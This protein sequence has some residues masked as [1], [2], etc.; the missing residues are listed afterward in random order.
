[1][2][3]ILSYEQSPPMSV[4]LPFYLAGTAWGVAA[5]AL[6]IWD[7]D[8]AVT[9][10][11]WSPAVMGGTHLVTLGV[12]AHFMIG[13]LF[14]LLP[15]VAG[16]GVAGGRVSAGLVLVGLSAGTFLLAA[17]LAGW[18]PRVM[19]AAAT[20]L[21]P[22]TVGFAA[23]LAHAAW[24]SPSWDGTGVTFRLAGLTLAA[25][26]VL[27]VLL[28][29]GAGAGLPVNV[30]LLLHL[31]V[32]TGALGWVLLLMVGVA[33]T[34]VPLFQVT[35]P[36]PPWL[37]RMWPAAMVSAL[38]SLAVVLALAPQGAPA[39]DAVLA[40]LVLVGCGQV[41]R[42]QAQSKRRS[43]VTRRFWQGAM[44]AFVL[45][46][47][48]WLAQLAWPAQFSP[49]TVHWWLGVL[50]LVAGGMGATHGMVFKIV[51]FLV[52]LHLKNQLPRRTPIP[53]MGQVIA[54]RPQRALLVAFAGVCVLLLAA[55]MS[56]GLAQAAGVALALEQL[57]LGGLLLRAVGTYQ[58]VLRHPPPLVERHRPPPADAA[59][60]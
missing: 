60:A 33:V 23:L 52:W 16:V 30:P 40:L 5:G 11:R 27:G 14:Q 44:G 56:R 24:R 58:R 59:K 25:V 12:L 10:G 57:A 20:V 55:P 7:V 36:F 34:V 42:L 17:G 8:S 2:S 43:D 51:P 3:T 1:M 22:T 53:T 47:L 13:S 28:V 39:L 4:P 29:A 45:A 31:H 37:G 18:M 49:R 48:L 9:L 26:G 41:L 38:L 50:V 32:A 21:G 54:E 6:L 19:V 35:P 15:V 46:A